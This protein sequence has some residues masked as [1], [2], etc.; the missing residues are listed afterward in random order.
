MQWQAPATIRYDMFYGITDFSSLET[1]GRF[2]VLG[3]VVWVVLLDGKPLW[4]TLEA[5][6]L[7]GFQILC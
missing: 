4:K 6:G 5:L 1:N 7:M 2:K 3:D